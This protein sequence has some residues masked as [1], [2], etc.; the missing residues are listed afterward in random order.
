MWLVERSQ[1]Q[2][3]QCMHISLSVLTTLQPLIKI[4]YS[5]DGDP[6]SSNTLWELGTH[7]ITMGENPFITDESTSQYTNM[8]NSP[9]WVNSDAP[10][11]GS[12]LWA[13]L[14]A[15]GPS[16]TQVSALD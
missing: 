10:L 15:A 14:G 16:S 12:Q 13:V 11:F 8:R 5:M 6:G 9:E 1:Q 7:P 3:A 2:I 4:Y